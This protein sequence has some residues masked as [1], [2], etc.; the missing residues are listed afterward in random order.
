MGSCAG[1]QGRV[2]WKGARVTMEVFSGS[3]LERVDEN[4]DKN[5]RLGAG[6]GDGRPLYQ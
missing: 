3:E 4:T 1:C 5:Q 6:T 2:L